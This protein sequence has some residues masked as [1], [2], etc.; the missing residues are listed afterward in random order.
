VRDYERRPHP[1]NFNKA[2][3]RSEIMAEES[4]GL[5]A[6]G[7]TIPSVYY[8][9]IA[10]V[11]A[12]VPFLTMILWGRDT[13]GEITLIKFLL[14]LGAGY[15]AGLLLTSV[16]VLW[17]WVDLLILLVL[18]GPFGWRDWSSRNDEIYVKDKD[19]GTTLA[20][21]EAE[22]TLCKNLLTGFLLLLILNDSGTF[23]VPAISAMDTHR[24]WKCIIIL[25]L[26]LS[27]IVRTALYRS[28]QNNLHDINYP[29]FQRS[30]GDRLPEMKAEEQPE[31]ERSEYPR[32][33]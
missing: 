22:A 2:E 24:Q 7:K 33:L 12:G 19:A 10:R 29:K 28:R 31:G 18:H 17:G 20:K 3:E 13:F 14:L 23:L 25:I 26:G 4:K 21:M 15:I 27:A 30:S 8:D 11:C 9:L 5:E 1:H 32:S 6:L 16:S